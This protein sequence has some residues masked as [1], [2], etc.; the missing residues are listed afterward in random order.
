MDFYDLV[1][2]N[3]IDNRAR[4][5]SVKDT[6]VFEKNSDLQENADIGMY[7]C[8]KRV[9]SE[10]HV[11]GPQIRNYYLFVLVNKGEAEFYHKNGTM[12]LC[13]HDMLVMCPDE[14]IHYAAKTSWSIQWVGLYGQTVKKYMQML[15]ISGD[16]PIIHIER[17]YEMEQ[18][19][20]DLYRLADARTEHL[21]CKQMELIYK[22]F[23]ILLE[24]SDKKALGDIADSAQK[25]I[26]YNFNREITV[27]EI[28]ATL[29]VDPAYLT[30][31]FTQKYG[32]SP[33]EYIVEKRIAHAK[34][35]LTETDATVT[36][37]SVSVGYADQLYFSRIFKKKEGVS[38][39]AYRSAAK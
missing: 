38:P 5:K 22:F 16:D 17:Y 33:K 32:L 11:Y 8:G 35:L 36:E 15:S 4:E 23:S 25:I 28:A 26:D 29:C 39:Q 7:H 10:N 14:K 1:W 9:H 21:K 18:L 13:E 27:S 3:C 24:N 6:T 34:R 12:K 19:L 31:R 20:E 37:I 30:R 2:Y